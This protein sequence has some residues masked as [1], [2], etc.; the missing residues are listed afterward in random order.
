MRLSEFRQLVEAEFGPNLEN[1]TPANVRE[2]LE[3]LQAENAEENRMPRYEMREEKAHTYEAIVK[4]FFARVL[5]MPEQEAVILLW[6]VAIE[7]AFAA[8]EYQYSDQL[9][10]LFQGLDE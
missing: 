4:D 1:A 7:L 2:F 6:M 5:E 3:R 9:D 10:P 8:V